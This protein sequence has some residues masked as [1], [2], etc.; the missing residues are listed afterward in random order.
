MNALLNTLTDWRDALS[1]RLPQGGIA[2]ALAT[3]LG[4]YLLLT[5]VLSI[6]WSMAPAAFDVQEHAAQH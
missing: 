1:D 5:L 3:L 2:K 4:L 6:Y